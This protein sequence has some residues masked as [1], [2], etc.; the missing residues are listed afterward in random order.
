[1]IESPEVWFRYR[2]DKV[3]RQQVRPGT[4]RRVRTADQILVVDG[5]QG[6]R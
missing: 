1:M 6:S 2:E 3:T 4:L 5:G